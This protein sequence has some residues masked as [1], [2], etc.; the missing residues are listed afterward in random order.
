MVLTPI[1][2]D[3]PIYH[4]PRATVGLIVANVF[5]FLLVES[6]VCGP[7]P[8][9]VA[10]YGLTHGQGPQPLQWITSNFLHA[11][12]VHLAGNMLFLW[13]FGL[14]VEGKIG[15]RAFLSLYLLMGA[16]ECAIEQVSFPG[17]SGASFG[18]SAVIFGLMAIALVWAPKNDLVVGYW[19]PGIGVGTFDVSIL[20]FSLIVVTMQG[21]LLWWIASTSELFLSSPLLHLLGALLGL[22]VGAVMWRCGWV[23]CEGWDL[24]SVLL[25]KQPQP[26]AS[27]SYIPVVERPVAERPDAHPKRDRPE[28]NGAM[29]PETG[30]A[31]HKARC[32]RRVRA[33]LDKGRP[34]DACNALRETQHVLDR[35]TLPRADHVRLAQSLQESGHCHEAVAL[36]EEYV[37]E[38]PEDSDPIRIEAAEM[39]VNQ[40]SRPHAAIRIL[41]P[42]DSTGL[43]PELHSRRAAILRRAAELIEQGAVEF[44]D[45]PRS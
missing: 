14:V 19:L 29:N 3:A 36:W 41:K 1:T 4:W 2:T 34:L 30:V 31:R 37:A 8:E 27:D 13:G 42:V 33:L 11:N 39:M 22:I 18:A 12:A 25:G 16:L 7:F 24:F 32:I 10:R 43:H 40:Q 26:V 15:W 5:V 23:D 6:G 44:A 35:W 28:S 20:T 38:H 9:I 17:V 21:L 45:R